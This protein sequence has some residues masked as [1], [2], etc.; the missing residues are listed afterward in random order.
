M[1]NQ[2]C[3]LCKGREEAPIDCVCFCHQTSR[4]D[5]D[6]AID[7]EDAY[8]K[9]YDPDLIADKKLDEQW[10]ENERPKET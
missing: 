7:A 9:E 10:R 2:H 1:L 4:E 6:D 3:D 5:I 8:A